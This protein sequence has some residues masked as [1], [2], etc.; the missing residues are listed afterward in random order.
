MKLIQFFFIEFPKQKKTIQNFQFQNILI[1][2]NSRKNIFLTQIKCYFTD[3]PIF[4][5]KLKS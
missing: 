3:P 4:S 1:S 2:L 5:R